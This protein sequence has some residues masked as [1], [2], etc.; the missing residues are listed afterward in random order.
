MKDCLSIEAVRV[1]M[2]VTSPVISY[3]SIVIPDKP[4]I[5]NIIESLYFEY[6]SRPLTTLKLIAE[7]PSILNINSL[8]VPA[9]LRNHTLCQYYRTPCSHQ[10]IHDFEG[11]SLRCDK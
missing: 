6:L 3:I 4:Q 11:E 2:L 5:S 8:D 1:L 9:P 10:T 7:C